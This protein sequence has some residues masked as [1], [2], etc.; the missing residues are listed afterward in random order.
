MS[1][2]ELNFDNHNVAICM[3]EVK[4]MYQMHSRLSGGQVKVMGHFQNSKSCDRIIYTLFA[5]FNKRWKQPNQIIK[6]VK[7]LTRKV[8]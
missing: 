8:A 2:R 3:S 7:T 5:Y 1:Y 4:D 6:N